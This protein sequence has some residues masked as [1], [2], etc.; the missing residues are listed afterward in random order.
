MSKPLEATRH[1]NST[2]YWSFYPSEPIQKA[3]FNMR[4]PVHISSSWNIEIW[5]HLQKIFQPIVVQGDP[6]CALL[7]EWDVNQNHVL[8]S[9][10]GSYYKKKHIVVCT[11]NR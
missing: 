2:K 6:T 4:H 9:L 1:N 8:P 5:M 7:E 3:R 11:E 10:I